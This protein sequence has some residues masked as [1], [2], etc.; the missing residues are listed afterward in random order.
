MTRANVVSAEL[1]GGPEDAPDR[2]V[3]ALDG[4]NLGSEAEQVEHDD[5][6]VNAAGRHPTGNVDAGPLASRSLCA[7][8]DAHRRQK[9]GSQMGFFDGAMSRAINE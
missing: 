1:A 4:Q 2:T 9:L 3:Y 5:V 6:R 8:D 7:C